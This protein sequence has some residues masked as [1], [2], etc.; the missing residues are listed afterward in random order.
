MFTFS[1][2][3]GKYVL[4]KKNKCIQFIDGF[5]ISVSSPVELFCKSLLNA[6]FSNEELTIHNQKVRIESVELLENDF[7]GEQIRVDLLSPVV[8]YSTL[9]KP[10]GKKLTHYYRPGDS[11][12][13]ELIT[14]NLKKKYASIYN[15]TPPDG[16]IKIKPRGRLKFN[17]TKY[18]GFIIKGYTGRVEV[19]GPHELLKI[20][21]DAGFGS[22][23]S[24]GFGCA[25]L[26]KVL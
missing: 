17:Q 21:V 19:Y 26:L 2:I 22:K 3:K 13:D 20:G 9:T 23:N 25:R 5:E 10:D 8:M 12:Y 24:Q 11:G 4:N 15:Q 7:V 6:M 14:N 18:K 16:R 1:Q